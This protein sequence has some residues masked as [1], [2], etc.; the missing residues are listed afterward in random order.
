MPDTKQGISRRS[1]V[2][3][4]AW[5]VPVIVVATAAPVMA[6]TGD[7]VIPLPVLNGRWFTSSGGTLGTATASMPTASPTY[8]RTRM[9]LNNSAAGSVSRLMTLTV[10]IT[11]PAS[12]TY[13][14]SPTAFD[15]GGS[16]DIKADP[17]SGGV[18]TSPAVTTQ[19]APWTWGVQNQPLAG[20]PIILTSPTF[21][22]NAGQ[23][24]PI[25]L[26]LISSPGAGTKWTSASVTPTIDGVVGSPVAIS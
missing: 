6:A 16:H 22:L 4:S 26:D 23:Q 18:I 21:T 17:T 5:S 14:L 11:P 2:V 25:K 8:L 20:D 10:S 24:M 15:T 13:K 3:G 1:I 12:T 7:P 9:A 19:D